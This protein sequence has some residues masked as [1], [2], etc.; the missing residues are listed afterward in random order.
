MSSKN[1]HYSFVVRSRSITLQRRLFRLQLIDLIWP[2]PFPSIEC[3]DHA[4][5][6]QLSEL[7]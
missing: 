3:S 5:P 7:N 6:S 1:V 2:D 4:N